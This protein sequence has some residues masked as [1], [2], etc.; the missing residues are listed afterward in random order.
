MSRSP[1]KHSGV[2]IYSEHLLTGEAAAG[3][4][5]ALRP[6]LRPS[7]RRVGLSR[8]NFLLASRSSVDILR[9]L[10]RITTPG[11]E[12][13]PQIDGLRFVAIL[14]V[15]AF[16]V[17]II[18]LFHLGYPQTEPATDLVNQFIAA[19]H[20]GV[21]LFFVV[22]GFVLALPF[23]RE[24]LAL[25]KKI[26]L[27]DYFLRRLTRMEPPYVIHLALLFLLC[28]FV[29]H[30]LASHQVF[31]GEQGWLAYAVS[32]IGASLVYANGFI[33]HVH[34]YPNMVLW[35]LEI[36]V[37]FYLLAPLL[38]KIFLVQPRW[39][40]RGILFLIVAVAPFI[41]GKYSAHYFVW[42]SLLGNLHYFLAGFLLADFYLAG[43]LRPAKKHL[44]WDAVFVFSVA[45]VAWINF[46]DAWN[47]LL[48]WILLA[49]C[50][51]TFLGSAMSRV[52]G[53]PWLTTIGGMCYTI[54]LYHL[55]VISSMF[56]VTLP[57]Q[58]HRLWLDLL[59]QFAVMLPVIIGVSAILFVLCERPFMRRDWPARFFRK[60]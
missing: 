45:A 36:E 12:F 16:H 23:A 7:S 4:R 56:R 26:S 32:H 5:P 15:I 30:R 2:P 52:L 60:K 3:R 22:S 48:P 34:P 13:I 40:R 11:R 10:S 8:E 51:A 47:F 24:H 42:A 46:H 49:G 25:G 39:F 31:Y 59:I 54:Y 58:T 44:A 6:R 38:A 1:F 43:E 18:G 27:R 37:Q 55:L 53:W 9:H 57:L 14:T 21:M 29:Y 41:A 35:S 17:R 33:F 20:Y 19:G 50:V 28:V